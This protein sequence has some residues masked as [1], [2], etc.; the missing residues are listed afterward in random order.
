MQELFAEM[1]CCGSPVRR[2]DKSVLHLLRGETGSHRRR[3]SG[4][5]TSRVPD[6]QGN[7]GRDSETL[8]RDYEK[9]GAHTNRAVGLTRRAGIAAS[10]RAHFLATRAVKRQ[11]ADRPTRCLGARAHCWC[12]P[13]PALGNR[14]HHP[15]S[16][17]R[18]RCTPGRVSNIRGDYG[19][20]VIA[21]VMA[22]R[23]AY[24]VMQAVH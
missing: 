18:L 16:S 22:A 12:L 19:G 1:P 3:L 2:V 9:H 6:D 24:F 11:Q 7:Q 5:P 17:A 13:D 8:G 21:S 15:L 4:C 23:T 14:R 10:P 20:V